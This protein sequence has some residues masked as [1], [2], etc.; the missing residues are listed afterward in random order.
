MHEALMKTWPIALAIAA[1]TLGGCEGASGIAAAILLGVATLITACGRSPRSA[2][3]GLAAMGSE[4]DATPPVAK[5]ATELEVAP[6]PSPVVEAPPAPLAPRARVR[7]V[8]AP[9]ARVFH[10]MLRGGPRW[11]PAK[12][13][14]R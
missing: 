8:D 6:A 9:D 1:T 3:P 5:P 7:R 11:T 2:E 14:P 13:E 12:D 4:D 10:P